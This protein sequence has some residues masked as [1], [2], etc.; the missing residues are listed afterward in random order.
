[1]YLNARYYYPTLGLFIQPDWFEVTKQGV[2]TNRYAYSANDP[3]NARDPS[4]NLWIAEAG[5]AGGGAGPAISIIPPAAAAAGLAQSEVQKASGGFF[6]WVGGILGGSQ[7][8]NSLSPQVVISK[9][10]AQPGMGHNGGPPLDEGNDDFNGGPN[11][12][13]PKTGT[14]IAAATGKTIEEIWSNSRVVTEN[15]TTRGTIIE[16]VPNGT[17]SDADADFDSLG[18]SNVLN[19]GPGRR[20]GT[21][22]D[23]TRVIVRPSKDGRPTIEFQTVS[24]SGN[25]RTTKEI[26]YGNQ[27]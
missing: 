12:P 10:D 5:G 14:L 23:G 25:V 2:G 17:R 4:G 27:N 9:G 8:S 7:S 1:M 21:L 22:P 13:D 11:E 15:V 18:F 16:S 6:S 26:R 3:V 20:M 19:I 24:P